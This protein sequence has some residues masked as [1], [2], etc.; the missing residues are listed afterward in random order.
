MNQVPYILLEN[1]LVKAASLLK[2]Q[3]I[4]AFPTETVYGL[5]A[6]YENDEAMKKIFSIKKRPNAKVFTC[7][8]SSLKMVEKIAEDIPQDFYLLAKAF[9]PGPLMII[10]KAKKNLS[11][12]LSQ[13]G[14]VG[15]RF[16]KHPLAIQFIETCGGIV[17]ATSAN[18]CD[19]KEAVSAQEVQ[20]IFTGFSLPILDGGVCLYKQASTILKLDELKILRQGAVTS[21]QI[22]QVL[23]KKLS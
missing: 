7:H 3:E 19:Q 2:N 16:V 9:L 13:D 6:D 22:E 10:L 11:Q 17:A 18:F 5:A 20:K 21:E 4:V 12:F 8:I 1:D 23:K 15:I 14:T